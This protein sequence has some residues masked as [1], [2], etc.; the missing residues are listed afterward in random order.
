MP[1]CPRATSALNEQKCGRRCVRPGGGSHAAPHASGPL[2]AL[3][4]GRLPAEGQGWG[5][6]R[7]K[8]PPPSPLDA[9]LLGSRGHEAPSGSGTPGAPS[10]PLSPGGT[11]ELPSG[12][13]LP[14]ASI[15]PARHLRGPL[16]T[17]SVRGS[18]LGRWPK[19]HVRPGG[20]A[21]IAGSRRLPACATSR[22]ATRSD[23]AFCTSALLTFGPDHSLLWGP[24]CAQQDVEQHPGLCPLDTPATPT[25]GGPSDPQAHPQTSPD[26]SRAQARPWLRTAAFFPDIFTLWPLN[27]ARSWRVSVKVKSTQK[28]L[29]RKLPDVQANTWCPLAKSSLTSGDCA[30]GARPLGPLVERR[31][32]LDAVPWTD[33]AFVARRR[34]RDI[35]KK[36]F[37]MSHTRSLNDKST[38]AVAIGR[39]A[40]PR[41]RP[42]SAPRP[43]PNPVAQVGVALRFPPL[44]RRDM[45][46]QR[47]SLRWVLVPPCVTPRL[48]CCESCSSSFWKIPRAQKKRPS[49]ARARPPGVCRVPPAFPAAW[50][51]RQ[52]TLSESKP[53][54]RD[55]NQTEIKNESP[56]T[57]GADGPDRLPVADEPLA[58]PRALPARPASDARALSR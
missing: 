48:L 1:P 35:F 47:E 9:G 33:I 10:S 18:D 3:C 14:S 41:A 45:E 38:T 20:G 13:P 34:L 25:L 7:P 19:H 53:K 22:P 31:W 8:L 32:F 26:V 27:L 29:Q 16:L 28:L 39:G 12:S 40:F 30:G 24:P 42:C 46:A 17:R 4:P 55:T 23:Q 54:S 36:F 5:S 56:R 50:N 43:L 6:S 15:R 21:G 2:S 44:Q 57:R 37:Q 11:R 58:G 49:T 52:E 51:T